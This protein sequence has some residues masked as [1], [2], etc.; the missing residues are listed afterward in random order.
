[1]LLL[2]NLTIVKVLTINSCALSHSKK[3]AYQNDKPLKINITIFMEDNPM[4]QEK[5]L[6]NIYPYR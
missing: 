5:F 2:C 4:E 3:K 6:T 1:M